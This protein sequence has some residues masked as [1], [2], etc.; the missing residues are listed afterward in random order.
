VAEYVLAMKGNI[1]LKRILGTI[2]VYPTLA[3]AN[4]YAA[5]QWRRAQV[6]RG[7]WTLLEAVQAW[8]RGTCGFWAVLKGF[9]ALLQD[10]RKAYATLT[11]QPMKTGGSGGSE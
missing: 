5:G 9:G 3:E 10:R 8:L 2:H 11:P 7:Q 1:G 4:K 6:T